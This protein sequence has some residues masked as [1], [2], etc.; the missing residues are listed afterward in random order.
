MYEALTTTE[1][2][3]LQSMLFEGT[4]DAFMLADLK[5]EDPD[6]YQVYRPAHR[7]IAGLFLEAGTELITR[8]DHE[9]A[10]LPD[11]RQPANGVP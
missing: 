4:E 6:W 10:A 9:Q 8:L 5:R 7:E 3:V 2:I 11:V 1:L